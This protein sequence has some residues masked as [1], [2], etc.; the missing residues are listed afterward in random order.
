MTLK[1]QLFLITLIA[2]ALLIALINVLR[3]NK[4]TDII[5]DYRVNLFANI[6]KSKVVRIQQSIEE[7]FYKGR[8]IAEEIIRQDS[9]VRVTGKSK[10]IDS[11]LNSYLHFNFSH[12]ALL[13]NEGK[14]TA[15][16]GTSKIASEKDYSKFINYGLNKKPFIKTWYFGNNKLINTISTPLWVNNK[17][18]GILIIEEL[19]NDILNTM[20]DYTGMG[21][22]GETYIGTS[23]SGT[24]FLHPLRFDL[25]AA[26]KKKLFSKDTSFAMNKALFLKK[27]GTCI[28]CID[29]RGKNVISSFQYIPE[30]EWGIVTEMDKEELFSTLRKIIIWYVIFALL[31][32][33]V[34]AIFAYGLGNFINKPLQKLVGT[35]NKFKLGDLSVRSDIRMKNEVGILANVFNEMAA[36]IENSTDRLNKSNQALNKFGYT[37][38]HDLKAPVQN[39]YSLAELIKGEFANKLLAG[40][41]LEMLDM[42][43]IKAKKMEELISNVLLMARSG[44][45]TIDKQQFQASIIAR[46]VITTL[47]IPANFKL[48]IQENM[49]EIYYN[50][51]ALFQ[52]FL[53]L[54]TNAIKYNDKTN[55]QIEVGYEDY[56]MK[57]CFYVK[58]NGKGIKE[59][60]YSRIF[61]IFSTTEESKSRQDSTGIGL[62]TVKSIVTENFGEVWVKSVPGEGSTFYFTI[63]K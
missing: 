9:M 22:T 37:I 12:I 24:Y 32:V 62:S 42:V 35:I 61:N 26:F 56:G 51:T 43:I 49:P 1:T 41:S 39:I 59:K 47:K 28:N 40:E 8:V 33:V 30:A 6:S 10:R 4:I 5:I 29:Y 53:N 58:D 25:N 48:T 52:I 55:G 21:N 45:Q 17:F 3:Y 13:N 23:D 7:K 18:D 2:G 15:S 16:A 11:I 34:L 63:P 54:I 44:N 38:S 36:T 46:D 50:K 31:G 14:I 20:N 60:D 27:G 57:H 19:D